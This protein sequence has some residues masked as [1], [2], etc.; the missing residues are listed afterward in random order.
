MSIRIKQN[1]VISAINLHTF[2]TSLT[3]HF[4]TI[5]LFQTEE[6]LHTAMNEVQTEYQK[7]LSECKRYRALSNTN[8]VQ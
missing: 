2:R 4:S 7:L 6:S 1:F 8:V 3:V 5:V